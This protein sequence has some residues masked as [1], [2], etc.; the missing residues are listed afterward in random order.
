MYGAAYTWL[1]QFLVVVNFFVTVG[2]ARWAW[3]LLS[4]AARN[5]SVLCPDDDRYDVG[6]MANLRQ[7]FGP[8]PMLWALPLPGSETRFEGLEFP[9]NPHPSC[10]S[11]PPI[12]EKAAAEEQ[13]QRKLV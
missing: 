12:E 2:Y 9:L 13:K 3:T 5:R 8:R 4:L 7:I 10:S 6:V 11:P 1:L